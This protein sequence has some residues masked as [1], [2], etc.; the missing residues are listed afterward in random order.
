MPVMQ[1]TQIRSLGWEDS[2]GGG[3]SNPFLYS[4]LENPHGQS[5]LA[6]YS[7]WGGKWVQALTLQMGRLRP[8][9]RRQNFGACPIYSGHQGC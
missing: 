1:D 3:H 2:P 5:S 8:S 6:G 9:P 7:P 4:C